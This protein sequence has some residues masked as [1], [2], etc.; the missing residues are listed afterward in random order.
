MPPHL[1]GGKAVNQRRRVLP[2][3]L[4]LCR[5]SECI[6]LKN[7]DFATKT[8]ISGNLVSFRQWQNHQRRDEVRRV[9][10]SRSA[11]LPLPDQPIQR[12][13]DG[14]QSP[15]VLGVI[16]NLDNVSLP[17]ESTS[18]TLQS[19]PT[20]PGHLSK[21]VDNRSSAVK[22]LAE[23]SQAATHPPRFTSTPPP[24]KSA[25]RPSA[26]KISQS[27]GTKFFSSGSRTATAPLNPSTEG[28]GRRIRSIPI[29]QTSDI[30]PIYNQLSSIRRHVQE[31]ITDTLDNLVKEQP[32]VFSCRPTKACPPLSEQRL[33]EALELDPDAIE[34]CAVLSHESWLTKTLDHIDSQLQHSPGQFSTH[35]RLLSGIVMKDIKREFQ[36]VMKMKEREWQRQYDA[37]PEQGPDCPPIIDTGRH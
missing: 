9:A 5:C 30:N 29:K 18:E 16:P 15:F 36:L 10:M 14:S 2:E 27:E 33:F 35:D 4:S 13:D 34:N 7:Y 12:M 25:S 21:D 23:T 19:T 24:E 11:N 37:S 17:L 28:Y 1:H 22:P 32:L 26:T 3:T 31:R 6:A 20:F 8:V